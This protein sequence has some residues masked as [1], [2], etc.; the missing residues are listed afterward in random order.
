MRNELLPRTT[1]KKIFYT[2]FILPLLLAS[3]IALAGPKKGV[4]VAV[5]LSPAGS[6]EIKGKVSGVVK[7]GKG[8]K[9]VAKKL[10]FKIAKLKTGLDLRD[11]H[12]KEKLSMKG[13][14][15][16]VIV[17]AIGKDG[18]GSGKIKVKGKTKKFKFT[19]KVEGK[20]VVA[21][22]PLSLKTFG[23]TGISYMGIGVQ[24]K[25]EVTAVVPLR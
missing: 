8:G 20:M 2:S 10:S 21:K 13:K 4:T 3:T 18:K 23:F 11:K 14:F 22:F 7:K 17:T 12:T 9:L 25:V 19:Y 15:P 24:D 1:M 6:F 5:E 16:A